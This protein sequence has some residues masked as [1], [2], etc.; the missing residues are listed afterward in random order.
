M[1]L[2]MNLYV[3]GMTP[4]SITASKNLKNICKKVGVLYDLKIIDILKDP[5][6]AKEKNI[7]A[8]PLLE[9]MHSMHT[10]KIIGDLSDVENI[11]VKLNLINTNGISK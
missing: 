6:I 8:T 4:L 1:K 9:M 5:K 10:T 7:L 2:R 3:T 11:L